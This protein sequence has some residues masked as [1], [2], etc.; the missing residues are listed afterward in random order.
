MW[1][2]YEA[3]ISLEYITLYISWLYDVYQLQ[4][5]GVGVYISML[6]LLIF[7]GAR[8]M[9]YVSKRAAFDWYFT[10]G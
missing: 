9:H 1:I 7:L 8:T 5:P 2:C 6:R 10:T 3:C 4:I